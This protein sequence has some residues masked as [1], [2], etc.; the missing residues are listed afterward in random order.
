MLVRSRRGY[1]IADH[2][3]TPEALVLGRRALL[4]AGAA[5]LPAAL[6]APAMAQGATASPP[7]PSAQAN[8]R[9][10]PGRDLTPEREATTYNNFYEFGSTKSIAREAARMPLRPW[11]IKVEGMVGKPREFDLDELI[12]LMPIEERTY[13]LRC[14]EGWSM[15]IPWTGFPLAELVKLVEPTASARFIAFQTAAIPSVMP[16]LRQSW[17][18]WPHTEGCTV[19]EAMNEVAFLAV[20]NYGKPLQ[21][22][23][24]APIRVLF[25]WKYGFKSGK[26]IVRMTFTDRQP[27]TFWNTIQP[28]EYGFWANVNPQVAHP[29]WSQATERV[30]GTGDRVP[31]Q[32]FNGYGEFV[33]GLYTNLQRER[34]WA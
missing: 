31:T 3:V 14:V 28:A 33:S 34:L 9:Y 11:T 2:Q 25:P 20:G 27:A 29:R 30:I 19:A 16:G 15:V 5:L 10:I 17:Y 32:L 23:N 22:A 1:E 21:G 26:S 24:G 18:P 6:A 7:L 4:G 8:A 12:R 13:R